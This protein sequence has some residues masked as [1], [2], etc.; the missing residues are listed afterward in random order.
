MKVGRYNG[1]A[2]WWCQLSGTQVV[3]DP[4][5]SGSEVDVAPWFNEAWHVAP[6]IPPERVAADVVVVSQHYA[7]H[8]HPAT[9]R[10]LPGQPEFVVVPQ[11]LKTV[12]RCRP[13]D[14]V[15][16][17]PP[18]P[19]S[20]LMV[21]GLRLWRLSRPWF[22]PPRY[23]VVV[24]ADPDGRAAVH[25]P[26]GLS[27]REA[28]LLASDLDITLMAISRD[29]FKLPFWLGGRVNPGNDAACQA[30]AATGAAKGMAIHD[31][32]K[33]A[34]G[35]VSRLAT[36]DRGP[37]PDDSGRWIDPAV[38]APTEGCGFEFTGQ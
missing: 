35:L 21:A 6:V 14:A 22:R 7:D 18:Y 30:L 24:L 8:C 2:T 25:A 3:F 33:R 12:R 38:G 16:V 36:V 31:E 10:V 17:L 15:H 32:D 4:W 27:A 37:W 19:D 28:S 20:P 13:G 29:L 34:Q 1:D 26:H 23:H 11:A 5:L 9:L